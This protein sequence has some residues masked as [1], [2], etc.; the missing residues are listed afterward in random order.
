M[1]CMKSFEKFC[2]GK[3]NIRVANLYSNKVNRKWG[4]RS[5]QIDRDTPLHMYR[6]YDRMTLETYW[7]KDES[8]S[9]REKNI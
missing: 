6:F 7:E 3:L 2:L 4:R 5:E 8:S 9:D 1:S